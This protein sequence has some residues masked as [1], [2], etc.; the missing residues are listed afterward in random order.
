[1]WNVWGSLALCTEASLNIDC[2]L[3]SIY[4]FNRF[5][6]Q[7][8]KQ[9]VDKVIYIEGWR[10]SPCTYLPMHFVWMRKRK[11]MNTR[12]SNN[13]DNNRVCCLMNRNPIQNWCICKFI[14]HT[15]ICEINI[16]TMFNQLKNIMTNAPINE[17]V[18]SEI[19]GTIFV[20]IATCSFWYFYVLQCA[21]ISTCN[22]KS[23]TICLL[24][25]ERL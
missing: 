18:T 4:V 7:K 14:S 17:T 8:T 13:Q 21:L 19:F 25:Q 16:E 6:F 11:F 24:L 2:I 1:M 15:A 22:N 12:N 10:R 20:R 9:I 5:S 3:R 23:I